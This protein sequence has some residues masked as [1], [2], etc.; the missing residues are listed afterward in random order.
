MDLEKIVVTF[1]GQ[2][3]QYNRVVDGVEQRMIGLARTAGIVGAGVNVPFIAAAGAMGALAY[4]TASLT[5]EMFRLTTAYQAAEVSLRV[6]TGSAEAGK[7]LLNEIVSLAVETPFKSPELLQGA[8]MLKAFGVETTQVVPVLR[9][10]GEVAAGVGVEKLPRIILAFGQVRVAGRLMGQELRQFIDANIPLIEALAKVMNKP[11]Q[12]IKGL[13]EEGRVSFADVTAAFK[14]LT[15]QGGLFFNL[16]EERSKTVEGRWSALVETIQISMRNI[17]IE[18]FEEFGIAEQL[19][20]AVKSLGGLNNQQVRNFFKEVH[21]HLDMANRLLKTANHWIHEAIKAVTGWAESNA[22]LVKF[23]E[24]VVLQVTLILAVILALVVAFKVMAVIVAIVF[25]PLGAALMALTAIVVALNA[26]GDMKS[27]GS[28]FLNTFTKLSKMV[29]DLGPALRDALLGEDW[30]LAGKIIGQGL[31]IVIMSVLYTLRFEIFY[32]T[33]ILG[34]RFET[35]MSRILAYGKAFGQL[36][37]EYFDPRLSE[38]EVNKR[39]QDRMSQINAPLDEAHNKYIAK[40]EA[41]KTRDIA[42][43]L[44]PYQQQVEALK[45]EAAL[46]RLKKEQPELLVMQDI[47]KKNQNLIFGTNEFFE[48]LMFEGRQVFGPTFDERSTTPEVQGWMKAYDDRMGA[49]LANTIY[50]AV[51]KEGYRKLAAKD[52]VPALVGQFRETL[53]IFKAIAFPGEVEIAGAQKKAR[54]AVTIPLQLDSRVVQ[55]A[56]KIKKEMSGGIWGGQMYNPFDRFNE[57]MNLLEQGHFG[58]AGNKGLFGWMF[59]K[60]GGPGSVLNRAELDFGMFEEYT[61]LRK[62]IGGREVQYPRTMYRGSQEAQDLINKSQFEQKSV[63]EEVRDT[64]RQ[65]LVIQE[66][67][68]DYAKQVVD[69]LR[70]IR[71]MNEADSALTGEYSGGGDF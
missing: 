59:G 13:V 7:K 52:E 33:R 11:V 57:R 51:G 5:A 54:D 10:L 4:A 65:A 55:M 26:I 2:A 19:D 28:E 64:L 66:Q 27:F 6:M 18:F 32:L 45:E 60:P 21:Y 48:R 40:M 56:D 68:R 43:A 53:D 44:A 12:S 71:G 35:E 34:S 58:P 25:S 14:Y 70:R 29:S 46:A 24:R 42:R 23:L 62:L 61:N 3:S 37:R 38:E 17:G 49:I 30:D 69:E 47:M 41:D 36:L 31:K 9:M 8:G 1:V 67:Q 50:E 15:S 39:F 20:E 63:Q 22:E 16:M